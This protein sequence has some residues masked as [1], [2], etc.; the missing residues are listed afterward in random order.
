MRR[1]FVVAS[2]LV[3]V[4]VL[5]AGAS[6]AGS[7]S[8]QQRWTITDLGALR[9]D[10]ESE[11]Q[12]INDEGQIVGSS[13]SVKERLFLW[14][15]GPWMTDLGVR[16]R[17]GGMWVEA[18]NE[19]GQV[20]G[21]TYTSAGEAAWS[22]PAYGVRGFIW[23]TGNTVDIGTIV[24]GE[25]TYAVDI[26]ERGQIIG[27]TISGEVRCDFGAADAHAFLWVNGKRTRLRPLGGTRTRAYDINNRGVIVGWTTTKT[28]SAAW[29]TGR[30]FMWQNGTMR[31]LGTLPGDTASVA[32]AVNESGQIIG[33]SISGYFYDDGMEAWC[34]L[35]A[36]PFLWQKS[37][38]TALPGYELVAINDVGQ[39]VGYSSRGVFLYQNGRLRWLG[40]EGDYE[41]AG[42][43]NNGQIIGSF[44]ASGYGLQ[45][46]V[47]QHGR[48][49]DLPSLGYSWS[50]PTAINE[51]GQI[52]G[53]IYGNGQQ[54]AVLWTPVNG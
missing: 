12:A 19:H 53:S 14:Q 1:V 48:M 13:W 17:G 24:R 54:H 21:N 2:L 52:V 7:G 30:A 15:G 6:C 22:S 18:I 35:R 5:L 16:Q 44:S 32:T 8:L 51:Q 38:M 23:Q 29:R 45:A 25:S 11:A 42:I 28:A 33:V 41:V 3:G 46:F 47:W 9:G 31:S 40:V 10:E 36:R 26:N 49:T 27:N 4:V 50:V 20:I 37:K 39:I 34:P 43:N